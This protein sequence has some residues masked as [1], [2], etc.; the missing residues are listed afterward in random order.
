MIRYTGGCAQGLSGFDLCGSVSPERV[1]LRII[2]LRQNA[3]IYDVADPSKGRGTR[4][5]KMETQN[6]HPV[7]NKTSD[8]YHNKY[9]RHKR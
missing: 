8:Y 3:S 2:L 9:P 7:V 5:G 4:G 1:L 6:K